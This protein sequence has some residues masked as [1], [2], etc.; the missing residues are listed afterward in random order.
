[1]PSLYLAL[2]MDI[3]DV[4]RVIASKDFDKGVLIYEALGRNDFLKSILAKGYSEYKAERLWEELEAIK[5]ELNVLPIMTVAEDNTPVDVRK[6]ILEAKS[7]FKKIKEKRQDLFSED[8]ET[9]RLAALQ[10]IE[11]SKRNKE[12]WN[13]YD[14]WKK[15][16]VLP[17]KQN[18]KSITN[19][20]AVQ[21]T[22]QL[23][24]DRNYVWKF[25]KKK[26]EDKKAISKEIAE[27][28]EARK[29]R[30]LQIENKLN[31]MQ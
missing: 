18:D 19:M 27:Q 11:L 20:N 2:A 8:R 13:T 9:R 3:V 12:C 31:R 4:N 6:Y 22:H 14:Y 28:I 29:M 25:G 1:M 7:C 5:E 26:E 21:L 17:G 24:L 16:G 30:I 23:A 15:H 10:I